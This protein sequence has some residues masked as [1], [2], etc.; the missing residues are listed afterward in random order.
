[1]A[2]LFLFARA[3]CTRGLQTAVALVHI[4]AQVDLAGHE[5]EKTTRVTGDRLRELSFINTTLFHLR[6]APSAWPRKAEH[7]DKR[8]S[9]IVTWIFEHAIPHAR[10][11]IVARAN[12][13]SRPIR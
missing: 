5:N 7:V 10:H 8:C 3:V 4:V 13:R 12:A 6:K 2:L 9:N 11:F 1:M